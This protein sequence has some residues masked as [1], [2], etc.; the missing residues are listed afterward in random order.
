MTWVCREPQYNFIQRCCMRILKC[1]PIPKHV[2]FIMDGNRRYADRKN[3]PCSDGHTHGFLKLWC[4]D[5]G[6][7]ELSVYA[8]SIENFKRKQSEV[9]F[10]F[11]LASEKL[12]ELLSKRF[13]FRLSSIDVFAIPFGFSDIDP[14]LL[15]GCLHS[16]MSRPLDLLIRTSGEVRLSDF[17]VWSAATSGTVHKFVGDFWPDFS[18]W[19]FAQAIL[20]YQLANTYLSVSVVQTDIISDL[21]PL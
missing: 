8:F 16:R 12:Q 13:C 9:T 11:Q 7:E 5:F 19:E 20:Y 10:L 4:K 14:Q 21:K 1:G 17:L 6:V 2:G 15:S 18:F 3:L